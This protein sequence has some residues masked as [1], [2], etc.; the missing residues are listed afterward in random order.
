MRIIVELVSIFSIRIMLYTHPS[1]LLGP[2]AIFQ[3]VRTLVAAWYC[4]Q[5]GRARIPCMMLPYPP[6]FWM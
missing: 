1:K 3:A 4:L 5:L 6:P 2:G